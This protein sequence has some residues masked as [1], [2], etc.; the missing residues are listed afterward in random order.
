MQRALEEAEVEF[1]PGGAVRLR[2]DP[3]TFGRDYLVDSTGSDYWPIDTAGR[4]SSTSRGRPLTMRH[5]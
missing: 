1:L 4:S 3:V 5:A 2:P